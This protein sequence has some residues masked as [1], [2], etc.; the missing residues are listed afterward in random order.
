[1]SEPKGVT[2][3][4]ADELRAFIGKNFDLTRC[5]RCGWP[6]Q[7][8]T[9]KGCVADNCSER[10][11]RPLHGDTFL[12]R[13]LLAA[14]DR[15]E[16]AEAKVRAADRVVAAAIR[17]LSNGGDYKDWPPDL[18]VSVLT[19]DYNALAKEVADFDRAGGGA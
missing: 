6:L 2:L 3:A 13:N 14:L 5:D 9:E 12:A 11:L 8:S 16:Q 7:D 17:L 1:M 18:L 19:S 10:P 4:D 15:L